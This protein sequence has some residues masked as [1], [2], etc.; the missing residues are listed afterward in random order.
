[1]NIYPRGSFCRTLKA[2][3]FL[4]IN[5]PDFKRNRKAEKSHKG[6]NG[7]IKGP[8]EGGKTNCDSSEKRVN[9]KIFSH[10]SNVNPRPA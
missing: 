9:S 1:M 4:D 2:V 5:Q 3:K 10:L 7:R 6:L 8:E